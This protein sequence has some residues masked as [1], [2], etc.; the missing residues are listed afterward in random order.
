VLFVQNITDGELAWLYRLS[1][2]L[3][4][5]SYEDF[6]LTPLEAASFGK[7]SIV[8]RWGGFLETQIE[9]VTAV[10]IDRPTP[11]HLRDALQVIDGRAWDAERIREHAERYSEEVFVQAIR[12][13]VKRTLGSLPA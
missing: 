3:I 5:I 6:G 1:T 9:N 11:E 4:A 13:V 12:D 10:F 2:A 8:L 7:P